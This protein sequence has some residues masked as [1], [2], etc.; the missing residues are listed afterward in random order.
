MKFIDTHIHLQDYKTRYA[1]DIIN[2]SEKIGVEKFICV[3][4]SPQDWDKVAE[5]S[6]QGDGRIIPAFGLHPWY[7]EQGGWD[8]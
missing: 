6:R 3:G 2:E 8:W 4:T 5:L 1:T 7:I